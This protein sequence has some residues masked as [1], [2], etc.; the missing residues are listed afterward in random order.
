MAANALGALRAIVVAK[1][2]TVNF[3][4]RAGMRHPYQR[5]LKWLRALFERPRQSELNSVSDITSNVP[6]GPGR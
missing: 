3:A 4:V 1:I 5:D 2:A 6:V